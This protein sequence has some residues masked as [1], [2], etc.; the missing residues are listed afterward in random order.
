MGKIGIDAGRPGL[1]EPRGRRLN[2]IIDKE[3]RE[4][5][6]DRIVKEIAAELRYVVSVSVD[7]VFHRLETSRKPFLYGD[8]LTKGL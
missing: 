8:G 3:M 1:I 4:A 5:S 2:G 7:V 6:I